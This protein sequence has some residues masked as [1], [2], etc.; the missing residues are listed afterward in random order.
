MDM[1]ISIIYYALI[2]VAVGGSTY[3]MIKRAKTEQISIQTEKVTKCT[4]EK[5]NSVKSKKNK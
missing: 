3:L 1:L 5:K 4:P 2:V